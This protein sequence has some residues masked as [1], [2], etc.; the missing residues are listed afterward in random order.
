MSTINPYDP[1]TGSPA[2]PPRVTA[3]PQPGSSLDFGR[4]LSFF[5]QDP[6]WVQKILVG[7]LFTLLS[8]V[9]IGGVFIAGYA[10]R[11][12]RRAARGETY[13][14]P[15][16]DDLGGWQSLARLA[17]GD[18]NGNTVIG[19]HLA[20]GTTGSIVRTDD[21]HLVVTLGL[22]DTIVV[23]T[24]GATLVANKHDEEQIRNVVKQ[25]EE[26]GWNEYL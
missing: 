9:F 4:S 20:V 22:K 5:F 17:G 11:L 18:E 10:V 8:F 13:P 1:P 15:E 26:L 7:S 12:L 16:W 3:P 25:L 14:L 21:Q 19:R 2:A 6:N 23:H 24:P